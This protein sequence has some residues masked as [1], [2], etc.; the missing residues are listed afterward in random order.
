MWKSVRILFRSGKKAYDNKKNLKV[1]RALLK[2]TEIKLTMANDGLECLKLC[3]HKKFDI[4]LMDYMIPEP[5]G[6]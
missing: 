2:R 1:V 3:R 4:I 5:D 6:V